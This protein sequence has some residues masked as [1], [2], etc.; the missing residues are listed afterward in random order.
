ME[1]NTITVE[2]TCGMCRQ[3]KALQLPASG[4]AAYKAGMLIQRAMPSVPE[5][6]RELL[7]SQICGPC[8]DKL[9]EEDEDA[10]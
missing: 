9:F 2:A 10:Q 1:N 4:Y 3:T 6:D 8:F 7:I 5:G